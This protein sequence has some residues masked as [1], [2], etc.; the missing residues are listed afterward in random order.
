MTDEEIRQRR[1]ADEIDRR[2]QEVCPRAFRDADDGRNPQASFL[3]ASWL[4]QN[5]W[6]AGTSG[7]GKSWL[8]WQL[9]RRIAMKGKRVA[10]IDSTLLHRY[11]R[12]HGE[13]REDIEIGIRYARAVL[14]DDFDKMLEGKDLLTLWDLIKVAADNGAVLITTTNITAREIRDWLMLDDKG[15]PL[16]GQSPQL[17]AICKTAVPMLRRLREDNKRGKTIKIEPKREG[18]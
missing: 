5:V 17:A 14:V 1:I 15:E 12:S 8:A 4:G 10:C 9:L 11:A 3:I 6:T 18:K 7:S 16:P 13:D 2:W